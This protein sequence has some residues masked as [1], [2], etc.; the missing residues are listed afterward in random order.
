MRPINYLV[1]WRGK[2]SNRLGAA[3]AMGAYEAVGTRTYRTAGTVGGVG[4]DGQ[5]W[6]HGDRGARCE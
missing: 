4:R 3:R 6:R 2:W 1:G 5:R